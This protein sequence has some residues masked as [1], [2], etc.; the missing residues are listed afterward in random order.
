M[1]GRGRGEPAY[2]AGEVPEGRGP[3][4]NVPSGTSSS[5]SQSSSSDDNVAIR[6]RGGYGS[7]VTIPK[8]IRQT[9]CQSMPKG[10]QQCHLM[11]NFIEITP[12]S[13]RTVYSYRFD[14]EPNIESKTLR[15]KIV[16]D[17]LSSQYF[18]KKLVFDGMF[19][20][21]SSVLLANQTTEVNINEPTPQIATLTVTV[22]NVGKMEWG[23]SE[24]LRLYNMG[25]RDFLRTL[26]FFPVQRGVFVHPEIATNIQGRDMKIFRGYDTAANLHENSKILMT[27][28]GVHK[29]VQ[30]KPVLEIMRE[31]ASRRPSNM[32]ESIRL[33]LHNKIVI[34]KYNYKCYK[35]EDV[36]FETRPT[37]TF[38]SA[39]DGISVSYIS[40]F[41][42][43]YNLTITDTAQPMLR[44][45][46]SNAARRRD[47]DSTQE[48]V[49]YVP[50]ELCSMAG[51]TENQSNDNR[52][53]MDL[54]KATQLL[55]MERV[56][57]LN[58]FLNK[59][60]N[61]STIREILDKWGYNYATEPKTVVAHTL[62]PEPIAYRNTLS[63]PVEQWTRI[64]PTSGSFEPSLMRESIAVSPNF[65][66]MTVVV[67][68]N[69][70]RN[71]RTILDLVKQGF[72]KVGLRVG[73]VDVMNIPDDRPQ[74][75]SN[76]LKQIDQSKTN[77]VMVIMSRQNKERYDVIKRL[78]T[79]DRGIPT[80]V[81]TSNL[82]MDQR[83]SR[84]AASKIAIQIAAKVGGEP[85]HVNIPLRA[86]MICGYDT[87]H[88]T[89]NRGRSFGAIVASTNDSYSRW[90]SNINSHERLEELSSNLSR[91]LVAAAKNWKTLNGKLP[92]RVILYRDGVGDGQLEHVFK[93]ELKQARRA[94]RKMS[95][96]DEM[97]IRLTVII[98]NKR[99]GARF[100]LKQGQNFT[101]PPPGT[102]I[103]NTVTRKERYDFY[104]I[105]Q[106]TR[107]GTISPTYYNII[108]DECGLPIDRIQMLSYKLTLNYYNWAGGVRVPAPCQYAH[109][110]AFQTGEN[111]HGPPNANLANFLHFL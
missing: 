41:Q 30:D 102:V 52:L 20:G 111:L 48:K 104:L 27:M 61:N 43:A 97:E 53:K 108:H 6:G 94:L 1:T 28:E 77:L 2:S 59:I 64:D 95:A 23:S 82:M 7:L 98:V 46:P 25:M 10:A 100:Y 85:W 5:G 37:S 9:K 56:R 91:D 22:K 55:P 79:C 68:S 12:M 32:P 19:D 110:L 50:P 84:S 76:A 66:H 4:M 88:D 40:Y 99:V 11:T 17:H 35:V 72:D 42:R 103:D 73:E 57:H 80:Q 24:M 87:Y 106:S 26:G 21:K 51:L 105:S 47:G 96:P 69:E 75:L 92:E 60:H 90:W 83:K 49:I 29:I 74:G 3:V 39:K 44:V 33:A 31:I 63:K 16:H 36:D 54:I 14:F 109:K 38:T 78:L 89:S 18:D 62:A 86:T 13:D 101:N 67:P 45:Q 70:S 8:N 93:V 15:R 65:K 81:I 71:Q 107:Q 58:I 34:T